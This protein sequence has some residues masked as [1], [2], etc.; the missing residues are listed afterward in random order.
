MHSMDL[1]K[2]PSE[3]H[4][5]YDVLRVTLGAMYGKPFPTME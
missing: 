3:F 2:A 5:H 4:T 1:K